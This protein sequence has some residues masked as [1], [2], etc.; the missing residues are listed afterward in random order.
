MHSILLA[1]EE[2]RTILRSQWIWDQERQHKNSPIEGHMKS[3]TNRFDHTLWYYEKHAEV[4]ISNTINA[5]MEDK[6]RCFL[7]YLPEGSRILDFGCDTGRDTKTF[8][9][10][11]YEVT[12]LDGSEMLCQIAGD[13]TGLPVRCMDFREYSPV[14]E[15]YYE[16]I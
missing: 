9:E 12:A 13:L 5:D 8:F 7:A 15:E 10:L 16:G 14:A 4:F 2:R 11:G 3:N 1:K 6:R